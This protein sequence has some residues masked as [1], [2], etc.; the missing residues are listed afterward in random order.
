[1]VRALARTIFAVVGLALA[2]GVYA[3]DKGADNKK[4]SSGDRKFMTEAAEGGLAEVELGKVAA[5]N[6]GSDDVKKFGQRMVDD[7]GKANEELKGVASKLGVNLPA[8]PSKKHRKEMDK[9]SKLNG[10]KFDKEYINAMVKDHEKDVKAFE[11]KA[12]KADTPEVQQFAS[13]TLPTL[14]DHLNMIK[15]MKAAEKGKGKAARSDKA[16]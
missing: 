9:L 15:D 2:C 6:G 10:D 8:E 1:M 4:V 14:Q 11:K 7:H 16:K 12:K 3:A 5:Q 13:A